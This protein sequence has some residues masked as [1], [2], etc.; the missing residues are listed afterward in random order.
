MVG[1]SSIFSIRC[2]VSAGF[3]AT[4]LRQIGCFLNYATETMLLKRV[5]LEY[6]F[7]HRMLRD[8]F[9]IRD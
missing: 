5:G 2:C 3:E 4:H 9:A 7:V 6:E 1:A 8:H